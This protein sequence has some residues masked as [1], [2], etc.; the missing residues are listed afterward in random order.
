LEAAVSIAEEQCG[1]EQGP[2]AEPT[3]HVELGERIYEG[4]DKEV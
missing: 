4:Q 2:F 1:S 3:N